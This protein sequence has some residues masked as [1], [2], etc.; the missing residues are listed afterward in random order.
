MHVYC[1]QH[2]KEEEIWR[3]LT[4]SRSCGRLAVGRSALLK[5]YNDMVQYMWVLLCRLVQMGEELLSYSEVTQAFPKHS[6]IRALVFN[7][8]IS[9]MCV[10]EGGDRL[11]LWSTS[12]KI[13]K[14]HL[15]RLRSHSEK[16]LHEFKSKCPTSPRHQR[17]NFW[18][19]TPFSCCA[20]GSSGLQNT[21]SCTKCTRQELNASFSK[22]KTSE[23]KHMCDS[24]HWGSLT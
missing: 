21:W 13:S 14:S 1:A 5:H 18:P 8:K 23:A 6:F 15:Q 4:S 11:L 20:L 2:S 19:L 3:W 17:T 22:D 24:L 9:F 12:L 10:Q 7:K 16:M